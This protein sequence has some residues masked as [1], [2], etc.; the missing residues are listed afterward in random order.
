MGERC[1]YVCSATVNG[2]ESFFLWFSDDRDGVV[3]NGDRIAT[4]PSRDSIARHCDDLSLNLSDE[5]TARYDFDAIDAWLRNPN[6]LSMDINS[7][8]K[9]WNIMD[10]FYH[11][12]LGH[13]AI[14][15]DDL[16]LHQKLSLSNF[17][18]SMPGVMV[19]ENYDPEWTA[20]DL[21]R[22]ATILDVGTAKFKAAL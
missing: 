6:V 14:A 22:L 4:F 13:N 1:Y 8:L 16:D 17:T 11:S 15:G 9:V 3:L 20:S 2:V 21:S 18:E 7:L 5:S 12:S 10:D 19:D